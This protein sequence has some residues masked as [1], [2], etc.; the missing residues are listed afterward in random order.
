MLFFL[1]LDFLNPFEYVPYSS[2]A[3]IFNNFSCTLSVTNESSRSITYNMIYNK[4][5]TLTIIV[6]NQEAFSI[7]AIIFIFTIEL[8]G[9]NS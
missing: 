4:Y 7:T 8:G 5:L 9:T 3:L 1:I 2:D 6:I